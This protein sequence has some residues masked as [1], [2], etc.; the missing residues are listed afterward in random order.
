MIHVKDTGEGIPEDALP[1]I[2]ER[3]YRVKHDPASSSGSGIGLS[4][5]RY[6][7]EAQGGELFVESELGRGTHFWFSLPVAN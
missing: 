1:F 5:A 7:V 6:F 3:F 4:I 2:F